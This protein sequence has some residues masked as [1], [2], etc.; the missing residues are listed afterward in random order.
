MPMAWLMRMS[1][2][3]M[4]KRHE[5]LKQAVVYAVMEPVTRS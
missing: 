3:L 4:P 1:S 5:R 2:V